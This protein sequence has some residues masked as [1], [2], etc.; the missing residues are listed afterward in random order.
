MLGT[1]ALTLALSLG[2]HSEAPT[3][4]IG[5][6]WSQAPMPCQEDEIIVGYG[7][8]HSDGMW[9]AYTCQVFDDITETAYAD[10]WDAA[11]AGLSYGEVA[12]GN[13]G[14]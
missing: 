7:D 6:A 10:G 11:N 8:F 4:V 13:N 14:N 2:N 9:D 3:P 1:V 5:D 12:G